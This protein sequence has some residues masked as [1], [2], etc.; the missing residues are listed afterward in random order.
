MNPYA[1]PASDVDKHDPILR[2]LAAFLIL[3]FALLH[4]IGSLL[5]LRGMGRL[6]DAGG[7]APLTVL[8]GFAGRLLLYA[9]APCFAFNAARGHRL[10]LA[11]AACM[12]LSLRS[13][14]FNYFYAFPHLMGAV[15]ATAGAWFSRRA[16]AKPR[17]DDQSNVP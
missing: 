5:Y 17:L 1:A 11:A 10:F 15:I 3:F 4:F 9:A 13:W 7:M 12:L 8:L 2:R 16:T 6:V 14:E